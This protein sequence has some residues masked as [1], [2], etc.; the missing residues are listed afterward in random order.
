V[1]A[2]IAFSLRR[3]WQGYW[4]NGLM[5]LAATASM[6]LMLL[7]LSGLVILLSGLDATL[8]YVE[9]KVE[10]VA[11]LEDSASPTDI[12]ALQAKLEAMPEI[13]SVSF[14]SKEQALK[15][16][17]A[18]QPDVAELVGALEDNP[19]PASFEIRLSD[20]IA[21]V[22]VATYLR[23]Q[24]I[25]DSVQDIK[26]T[27]NQ[28]V[29]VINLLRTGGVAILLVVGLTVLFI[30]INAI[31]LAVVARA[32]EIEIMKLVGASDAFIRWPFV[33]EGALVGLFG[34]L[35]TLGLLWLVQD[36]LAG[37][38]AEFFAVLPVQANAIV[39]RNVALIVL[40]TGIG[41]GVLGSYV[42]V[43]SYLAR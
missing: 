24:P 29:A 11:Y 14:V 35:I 4:R 42:S 9:S 36:R 1:P 27:V 31:R 30:I 32:E 2:F 26:K 43:R 18:R 34:A 19:L 33:F 20:P 17:Q 25:V 8:S 15:D 12:N 21:Y 38:L 37:A 13:T 22:D 7:L 16:F 10:V 23:E 5:S 41:V 6:T 39:G 28:M 3:A 40:P